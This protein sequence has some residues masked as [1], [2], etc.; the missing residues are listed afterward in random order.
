MTTKMKTETKSVDETFH[1][2]AIDCKYKVRLEKELAKAKDHLRVYNDQVAGFMTEIEEAK[3]SIYCTSADRLKLIFRYYWFVQHGIMLDKFMYSLGAICCRDTFLENNA[4]FI[5]FKTN[6]SDIVLFINIEDVN[7]LPPYAKHDLW[8]KAVLDD[9][10]TM[11]EEDFINKGFAELCL[12][13]SNTSFSKID[14][15][16]KWKFLKHH[17]P[18]GSDTK[19]NI[20]IFHHVEGTFLM[21]YPEHIVR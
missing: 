4:E 19:H 10:T 12:K 21:I 13:K 18:R 1:G 14:F 5:E 16:H 9:K 15:L 7:K 17:D 3:D 2:F 20:E 6:H 11:S 8:I